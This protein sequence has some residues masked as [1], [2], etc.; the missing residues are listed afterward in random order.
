MSVELG[1]QLFEKLVQDETPSA[2]TGKLTGM[3]LQGS[4]GSEW[5]SRTPEETEKGKMYLEKLIENRSFRRKETLRAFSVLGQ[6]RM[7]SGTQCLVPS[8]FE[9]VGASVNAKLRVLHF[10]RVSASYARHS[11]RHLIFPNSKVYVGK[12]RVEQA[13]WTQYGEETAPSFRGR[14]HPSQVREGDPAPGQPVYF[15]ESGSAVLDPFT[16]ELRRHVS[17]VVPRAGDLLCGVI[18]RAGSGRRIFSLWFICS[19]QFLRCWTL[20]L[21]R[22]HASYRTIKTKK[23]TPLEYWMTG[24]RLMTNSY[25][26]WGLGENNAGRTICPLEARQRYWH[27]RTEPSSILWVHL[28]CALVL[29]VRYWEPPSLENTPR[30]PGTTLD[31]HLPSLWLETLLRVHGGN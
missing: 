5:G 13:L 12:E 25:Y 11:N 19:E 18:G 22:D 27:L 9:A 24:N 16:F 29:V 28:Y 3:F 10:R 15:R 1:T 4:E 31:W 30:I 2:F 14:T 17:C 20:C 6:A 23:K 8:V 21:H 7:M 26:K